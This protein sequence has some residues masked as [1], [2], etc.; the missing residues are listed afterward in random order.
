MVKKP[1]STP[2]V[3]PFDFSS[4][5]KKAAS[6]DCKPPSEEQIAKEAW[7]LRE[8]LIPTFV[9]DAILGE[10]MFTAY[11]FRRYLQELKKDLGGT[12]DRLED[13]LIEQVALIHF[14]LG[15]LHYAAAGSKTADE[16]KAFTA[17]AARLLGEMRRTI[18]TLHG[19]RGKRKTA[20]PAPVPMKKAS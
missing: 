5:L 4:F 19:R 6:P 10:T 2:K 7:F 16:A 12:F 17:G 14:R 20:S 11:G 9:S 1:G 8:L 15:A 13:M 18:E 3:D